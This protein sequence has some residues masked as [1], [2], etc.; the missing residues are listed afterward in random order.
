MS[1]FLGV[2]GQ[3][4]PMVTWHVLIIREKI[5]AIFYLFH[6]NANHKQLAVSLCLTTA[7]VGMRGN[8][9]KIARIAVYCGDAS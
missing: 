3:E 4:K 5:T 2:G 7:V 6:L 9:F 1:I 8:M